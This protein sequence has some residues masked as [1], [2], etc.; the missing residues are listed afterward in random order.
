M[1]EHSEEALFREIND[2][3]RQD[4]IAKIWKRYG[5]YILGVTIAIIIGVAGYQG[6]KTYDTHHREKY[7]ERLHAAFTLAAQGKIDAAVTD[8]NALAKKAGGGYAMIARFKEAALLLEKKDASGAIAIYDALSAN[9]SLDPLYRDIAAIESAQAS[10]SLPGAEAHADAVIKRLQPIEAADNPLRFSAQ[11]VSAAYYLK[12]G[13]RK[14]AHD[15]F[16]AIAT[17]ASA[18]QSLRTRAGE[19]AAALAAN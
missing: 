13:D 8:L 19:L 11:E 16:N 14:K 5:A 9:A 10:I 3:L 12:K 1:A 2:E 7:G 15:L 17:D 4:S 6:W 18:P